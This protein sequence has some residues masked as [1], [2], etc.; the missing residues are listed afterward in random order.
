M[1]DLARQYIFTSSTAILK[2]CQ[3]MCKQPQCTVKLH[4][5]PG[6]IIGA[7]LVLVL[8]LPKKGGER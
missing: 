6:R 1:T 5:G 2:L 4:I 8:D 3:S 7:Y